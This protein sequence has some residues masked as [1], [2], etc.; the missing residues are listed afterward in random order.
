MARVHFQPNRLEQQPDPNR[1]WVTLPLYQLQDWQNQ[2]SQSLLQNDA[3]NPG[4]PD[5]AITAWMRDPYDPFGVANTRP[6]AWVGDRDDVPQQS[7]RVA[8]DSLFSQDTMESVTRAEQLYV[9]ASMILGPRPE[10]VRLSAAYQPS[11]T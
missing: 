3:L 5:P 9:I 2:Q 10:S 11:N 6:A 8:G 7:H 1:Y 4:T